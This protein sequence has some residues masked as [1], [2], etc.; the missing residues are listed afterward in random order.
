MPDFGSTSLTSAV[1]P[2]TMVESFPCSSLPVTVLSSSISRIPSN[3]ATSFDSSA[4]LEAVPPTWKVRRVSCVPGSPIDCA[5]TTPTA[6]PSP[7][8]R[9]VARFLP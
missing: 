9:L 5:A 7:A 8:I 2:I 6:S 1:R 4:V 3:L